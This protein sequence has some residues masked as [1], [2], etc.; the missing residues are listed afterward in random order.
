MNKY[1]SLPPTL[2]PEGVDHMFQNVRTHSAAFA[3]RRNIQRQPSASI[4]PCFSLV[5]KEGLERL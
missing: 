5:F 3:Q 2:F 1:A 4:E